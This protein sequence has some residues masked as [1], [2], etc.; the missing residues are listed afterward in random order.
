MAVLH[1]LWRYCS[2]F[3]ILSQSTLSEQRDVHSN[4][5]LDEQEMLE[6]E[7][8]HYLY[9]NNNYKK[10][11]KN[12]K[13]F[14]QR[15]Q[16]S[17]SAFKLPVTINIV[18]LGLNN[19]PFSIP[20][21]H[22]NVN[23]L[24]QMLQEQMSL[25][26][27]W[28]GA[29][30]ERP[31][32]IHF[33]ITYQVAHL[34][35][36][37]LTKFETLLR[38]SM[39]PD[40]SSPFSSPTSSSSS[41]SLSSSSSTTTST[42]TTLSDPTPFT[43]TITNRAKIPLTS[44]FEEQLDLLVETNMENNNAKHT[45]FILAP[46]KRKI[47]PS[48]LPQGVDDNW[49]YTY[50]NNDR[51]YPSTSFHWLSRGRHLIV[52]VTA[53][54]TLSSSSSFILPST[55]PT[56]IKTKT[57]DIIFLAQLHSFLMKHIP[58]YFVPDVSWCMTPA[59]SLPQDVSVPIVTFY[60]IDI[61]DIVNSFKNKVQLNVLKLRKVISAF[62]LPEQ[63]IN[64]M[65]NKH[66]KLKDNFKVATLLW[67]SYATETI[68]NY[69]M[70][71]I[72]VAKHRTYIDG[73]YIEQRILDRLLMMEITND[74]SEDTILL[75]RT[76]ETINLKDSSK[77]KSSFTTNNKIHQVTASIL[78]IYIFVVNSNSIT[79]HDGTKKWMG[80]R[81]ILILEYADDA[82]T[83]SDVLG[84]TLLECLL[85]SMFGMKSL[86]GVQSVTTSK[87]VSQIMIDVS[88]KYSVIVRLESIIESIK[89]IILI[90]DEHARKHFGYISHTIFNYNTSQGVKNEFNDNFI[91]VSTQEKIDEVITKLIHLYTSHFQKE[92]VLLSSYKEITTLF[93]DVNKIYQRFQS[94]IERSN[95]ELSCCTIQ[96][97]RIQHFSNQIGW[98]ILCI[99]VV[100]V[101]GLAFIV[102][103]V[104]EKCASLN[105]GGRKRF[106]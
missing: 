69:N 57:T 39:L 50:E 16:F 7:L 22:V 31:L 102:R 67:D 28:C 45:I 41:S 52:D 1:A 104:L 19:P 35:N 30:K 36:N 33:N 43:S 68:Y 13:S 85:D 92:D 32:N 29:S 64:L 58:I 51:K 8:R 100:I 70:N 34:S 97:D 77:D 56:A 95:N 79:F 103:V 48:F 27:P 99:L 3:F 65:S 63:K 60:D 26:T 5:I 89:N 105:R 83:S 75:Q 82:T 84:S 42:T 25:Y 55:T 54:T 76:G 38:K 6:Q 106:V 90:I 47:L 17:S 91:L 9:D 74:P 66:L 12:D 62:L 80:D 72:F 14:L 61:D 93:Y 2:L 101:I 11:K 18:L 24:K 40:T 10:Y 44:S 49:M 20:S 71:N 53:S 21:H 88:L 86:N 37:A 15:Q 59:I 96:F 23:Q 87:P 46:R 78:P 81:F 4:K 73:S 98:M 94:A